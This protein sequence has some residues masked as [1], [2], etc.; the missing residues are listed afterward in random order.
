MVPNK[1][2]DTDEYKLS[3]DTEDFLNKILILIQQKI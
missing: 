1:G 3:P 2:S